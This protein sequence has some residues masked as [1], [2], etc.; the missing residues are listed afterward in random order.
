[1]ENSFNMLAYK[2]INEFSNK[3]LFTCLMVSIYSFYIGCA[4]AY[5][6]LG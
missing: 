1:M 6:I 5:L 3:H 2:K 4:F